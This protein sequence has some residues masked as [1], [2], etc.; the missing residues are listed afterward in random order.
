[1]K[2]ALC[3]LGKAGI[4]VLRAVHNT[5]ETELVVAFCR[6]D[7]PKAGKRISDVL[8]VKL[9][10]TPIVEVRNAQTALKQYAP[11][12]LIDFSDKD[13]TLQLA[14]ACA[15]TGVGIVICTTGFSDE[16]M[17]FLKRVAQ[18]DGAAMVYAPN[19]TIGINVSM[20]MAVQM[21]KMLPDFD[22]VIT[23]RH[24]NQKKDSISA[25]AQ[26]I[27]RL[28]DLQ[29]GKEPPI[30]A[31]RAGG[32]VGYHEVSAVGQY[33]RVTIIHESFSR[34]A[35]AQGALMAARYLQGKHGWHVMADF[36]SDYLENKQA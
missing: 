19:V 8:P 13:A 5:P 18:Q 2:I 10:D 14:P 30:I 7:S 28:L 20:Q 34:Q 3:G 11:D 25:T 17:D 15:A 35:F 29:L 22:Y 16:E 23:E 4:R 33:E 1:M 6:N 12:V 36:V 21:A 26:V 24:H 31:M 32:Y 27:G 9:F